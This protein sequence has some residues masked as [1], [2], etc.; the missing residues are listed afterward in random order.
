MRTQSYSTLLSAV[1]AVVFTGLPASV[2]AQEVPR[3]LD[4]R[5]ALDGVWHFNTT[6]PKR[7]MRP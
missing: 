3:Q 7:S 6:T 4:G 1:V 2:A 5:P